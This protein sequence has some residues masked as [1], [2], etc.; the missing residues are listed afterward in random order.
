MTMWK[1]VVF[2]FLFVCQYAA[3]DAAPVEST[4]Y[5][6]TSLSWPEVVKYAEANLP[7]KGRLLQKSDGYVYLK[8]D[9]EYI[10][11]LFPML[12]LD[13]GYK[14]P[15]YFRTKEAPGAHIS[16]FYSGENVYPEEIGRIY[17]FELKD[18]AIVKPAKDTLYVIL[19]VESKELESLRKKYGLSPK[20]HNHEYHISLA[21]KKL[22]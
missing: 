22:H 7:L 1:W 10:H 3:I 12:G 13:K 5:I 17:H 9:D 6:H 20:L 18:I 15:P 14:E 21:I 16:I 11:R 19:Q 8:V 2:C 4:A